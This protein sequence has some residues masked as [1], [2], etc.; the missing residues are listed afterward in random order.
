MITKFRFKEYYIWKF[1]TIIFL[2][3]EEATNIKFNFYGKI[4]SGTPNMLSRWK[5]VIDNCNFQMGVV[6]GDHF[7]KKHFSETAKNK[8][9]DM[10]KYIMEELKLRLKNNDWMED[11]TKIISFRKII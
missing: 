2:F 10:V 4:L 9:M 8:A 11:E 5:R 1:L 3:N 6:I 7:V